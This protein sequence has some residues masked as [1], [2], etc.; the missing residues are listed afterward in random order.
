MSRGLNMKIKLFVLI[1][2]LVV[3]MSVWAG[4]IDEAQPLSVGLINILDFLLAIVG[5]VAIIG[6]TIAG[7]M[8]FFAAGDMRQIA[9]AKKVTLSAITGIVIAL[10]SYVLVRTLTSFLN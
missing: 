5:V 6:L 9:L 3:P 4:V 1:V 10:G 8:Y 2:L 7:F